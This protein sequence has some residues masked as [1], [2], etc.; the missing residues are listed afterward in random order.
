M[1]SAGQTDYITYLRTL[2]DAYGIQ[3]KYLETLRAFHQS[4]ININNL[5]GQ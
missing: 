3:V 1:F 5:I 4:V 2:S